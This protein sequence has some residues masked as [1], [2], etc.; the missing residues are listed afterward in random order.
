MI[1]ATGLTKSYHLDGVDAA[2]LHG[3]DLEV[4]AGQ[5]LAITGPSGCGKSTLLHLLGG[6]DVP[7]AGSVTIAGQ[8]LHGLNE[9]ARALLRRRLV[10]VVFQFYNLVPHLT[11]LG[12]VTLPLALVG[13]RGAAARRMAL[14]LL[15]EVGL[16]DHAGKFP[17]QL[18]G[19]QQQRVALARAFANDPGVLLADEPTGALDSD[20][21][22]SV[23]GLLAERHRRGQTIVLVTHD[24]EVAARAERTV[25]MR[26]GRIV[27]D[28]LALASV[29]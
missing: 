7:D 14:A 27:D 12:N 18:S 20:A 17:G 6:L 9:T 1:T 3:L 15:D 11:V 4:P 19:G 10:G 24:P 25:A 21:A 29:G 23:L 16:A 28:R 22:G 8:S 13:T 2:V 26:D 5:W